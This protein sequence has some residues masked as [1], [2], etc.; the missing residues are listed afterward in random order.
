M[1]DNKNIQLVDK[2]W[3]HM[4]SVL[5][6][7]MPTNKRKRRA[8]VWFFLS[9]A[10]ITLAFFLLYP[11]TH[12]NEKSDVE[13]PLIAE[14]INDAKSQK[15][16]QAKVTAIKENDNNYHKEELPLAE[17]KPSEKSA[18]LSQKAITS[19]K[20]NTLINTNPQ[21]SLPD[22][23]I[24]TETEKI[25][26]LY[27]NT[28]SVA[29]NQSHRGKLLS[30]E[31]SVSN[32]NNEI[33]K[34]DIITTVSNVVSSQQILNNITQEQSTTIGKSQRTQT[35]ILDKLLIKTTPAVQLRD[36][37]IY[38]PSMMDKFVFPK[39]EE[40]T[41][42]SY[43]NYV[44]AGGIFDTKP[45]G[46]GFQLGLGRSVALGGFDL[47]GEI[48]YSN[49]RYT[50]KIDEYEVVDLDFDVESSASNI[51][52]ENIQEI[53]VLKNMINS[54]RISNNSLVTQLDYI[55]F[56]LGI[57]KTIYKRF[58]MNGGVSISRFLRIKNKELSFLSSSFGELTPSLES[59]NVSSTDLFDN[60]Q[61]RKYE[62]SLFLG[63]RYELSSRVNLSA[64]GRYALSNLYKNK[65]NSSLEADFPMVGSDLTDGGNYTLNRIGLEMNLMYKF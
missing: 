10:L 30:V 53:F 19:Q 51:T 61:F 8:I 44:F 47:F 48:G 20:K 2:G 4:S 31:K 27:V 42:K 14:N 37:H 56:R 33:S 15:K 40:K 59:F 16:D 25:D 49:I 29:D 58:S 26:K 7:E 1:S 9:G 18:E 35:G 63:F 41:P 55:S 62:S 34:E 60:E 46:L 6:V 24:E 23:G 3:S 32:S 28:I 64:T 5:D 39:V 13:T 57:E 11:D 45:S 21:L 12:S 54:K 65:N 36:E 50:N 22:Y 52:A 17:T 38:I 43:K